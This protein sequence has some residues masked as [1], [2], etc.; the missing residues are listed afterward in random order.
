MTRSND[1]PHSFKGAQECF[2][3]PFA[4]DRANSCQ[5]F[6]SDNRAEINARG[7]LFVEFTNQ[8]QVFRRTD[9]VDIDVGIDEVLCD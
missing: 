9:K 2:D 3:V 7:F 8:G 4:R 5:E 6:L 1:T